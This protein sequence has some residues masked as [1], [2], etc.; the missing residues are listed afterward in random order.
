MDFSDSFCS[1][2]LR[3]SAAV[4][5]PLMTDPLNANISETQCQIVRDQRTAMAAKIYAK[6]RVA[7]DRQ[8]AVVEG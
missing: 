7:D 3:D 1:R 4:H 6:F 5:S 2:V 8:E